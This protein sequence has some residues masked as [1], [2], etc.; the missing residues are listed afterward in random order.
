[1]TG[2]DG[3]GRDALPKLEGPEGEPWD[4][5]A[6]RRDS[7]WMCHEL[8]G[9]GAAEPGARIALDLLF[10]AFVDRPDPKG[11]VKALEKEGFTAEAWE[12]DGDKQLGAAAADAV[13]DPADIWWFEA[14]ATICALRHGYAPDGWGFAEEGGAEA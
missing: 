9:Q 2:R 4:W 1:M 13:F 3:G 11:A 12:E 5:E 6:Q 7:E 14:R 10:T 8:R